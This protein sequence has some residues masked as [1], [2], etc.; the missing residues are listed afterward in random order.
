MVRGSRLPLPAKTDQGTMLRRAYDWVIAQADHPY[1]FWLMVG[2]SFLESSVL[3]ILPDLI[4]MPMILAHRRHA[5]WLATA[6]TVSSVLG[7]YLG[8]LIGA[9]A[10]HTV[11]IWLVQHFWTIEGF[12][13]AQ[14]TFDRYGFWLIVGKGATPIPFKIV[15]ILCGVMRYDLFWFTIA[16]VIARGMRFYLLAALLYFFGD[17]IRVFIERHLPWVLTGIVLLLVVGF[18][19]LRYF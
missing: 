10:F 8:Y 18:A 13:R 2:I 5:F 12:T 1:A 7:G 19:G 4:L 15:T 16:S 11:G 3:P 9:F 14:A 6:A 17:R